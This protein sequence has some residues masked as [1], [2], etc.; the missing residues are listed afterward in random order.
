MSIEQCWKTWQEVAGLAKGRRIVL[1]GRSEDWIP[2]TLKKLPNAADYIVDMNEGYHGTT[3]QGLPVYPPQHLF[4]DNRDDTYVVITSG[5]YEGIREILEDNG[6]EAGEQYCCCP[7]YRDFLVL[8]NI[9]NHDQRV[10]LTCCDYNDSSRTRGSRGGGGIFRYDLLSGELNRVAGPGQYRQVAVVGDRVYAVEYVRRLV[11]VFSHGF[12]LIDEFPLDHPNYCGI[13]HHA[14]SDSLALVNCSTDEIRIHDRETFALKQTAPFSSKS[15][16]DAPVTSPHHLN[17]LC[18]D[19]DSLYVTYFSRS[20]NWKL[21]QYDGGLCEY[22]IGDDGLLDGGPIEVVRDLWSPHSPQIIQGNLCYLDSMR[23]DFHLVNQT[24]AGSFNG[25]VRGLAHD[26]TFYYIGVSEDMYL[27]RVFS[28]R[29]SIMLNAGFF[30]FE[31]QTKAC[32][33]FPMLDHMN[34]HDLFLLPDGA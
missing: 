6:F 5:V 12:E 25:F 27:S 32:R 3:F 7:E 33:F 23:G 9:R 20:G 10:Y 26:G 16:S 11:H 29:P 34:I 4:D 18:I 15:G 22:R 13:A 31:P 14:A 19:G 2:K 24:V 1:Y 30:L 17:D 8:D 21:G 28:V